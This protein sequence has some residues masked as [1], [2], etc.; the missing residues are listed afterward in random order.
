MAVQYRDYYE[1][2]GI[3]KTATQDEVRK[4]FRKLARKHHPDV[5]EEKDKKA[6]EA[7]FKEINEAYEVLG[8]P[9]KRKKYDQ[10]GPSWQEYAGAGAG[11]QPRRG[12]GRTAAGFPPEP[13]FEFGGTGF[14]D[15]FEQFFGGG[16]RFS[17]GG[18]TDGSRMGFGAVR[19]QDVEADLMVTI[20]EVL[21]GSKRTVSFRRGHEGK[22]ETYT[23]KI[24]PG[25]REG[26]RIRLAGRGEAG[27]QGGEAGDLYLNVR[28]A[29]HP[30]YEIDGNDLIY[31][32]QLEP[33][34]LVL[35]AEIAVP[36]P[37]G[38]V[39]LKVRPGSQVGQKLRLRGKGL[40]G[41]TTGT[42]GDFYVVLEVVIPTELTKEQRAAWEK[43]ATG[44]SSRTT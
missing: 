21:H 8:D 30:D 11:P 27:A 35:G 32:V 18:F 40:P 6:A 24:P 41:M 16:A 34:Q 37:D 5:A 43:L 42:R 29:K 10:L 25:V 23:V 33:W 39:K 9:E 7:K 19:G 44:N 2:L 13:D 17:R 31:R 1:I 22:V 28:I 20:D 38:R 12:R 26:K 15:F 36:T 14:S 4:A 3:S